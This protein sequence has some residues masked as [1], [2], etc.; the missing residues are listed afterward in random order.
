MRYIALSNFSYLRRRDRNLHARSHAQNNHRSSLS[1]SPA[2]AERLVLG[3][4][5]PRLPAWHPNTKGPTLFSC[6]PTKI[7]EILHPSASRQTSY[8]YLRHLKLPSRY[9]LS[10]KK[11][12]KKKRKEKKRQP[13]LA[14]PYS[15][16]LPH[17]VALALPSLTNRPSFTASKPAPLFH[18]ISEHPTKGET[19]SKRS[20]LQTHLPTT[21]SYRRGP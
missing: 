17:Q 5:P 14:A 13:S 21:I 18:I 7:F 12:G 3:I 9:S 20:T 1:S 4:P 6:H 16:R 10:T 19:R 2:Q 11:I 8:Q 15:T